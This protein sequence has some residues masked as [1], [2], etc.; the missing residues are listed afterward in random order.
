[1]PKAIWVQ[2]RKEMKHSCI[3][4]STHTREFI[5]ILRALVLFAF[6]EM[7]C[8]YFVRM[9]NIPISEM[10]RDS[11]AIRSHLNFNRLNYVF[12]I[13]RFNEIF[14]FLL[15][16]GGIHSRWFTCGLI[17]QSMLDFE[18]VLCEK[19]HNNWNERTVDKNANS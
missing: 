14:F 2:E 16:R 19:Q 7:N 17:I 13:S 18:S 4:T 1:M 9:R 15:E 10:I 12:H 6:C 5:F 3:H 8:V 11:D